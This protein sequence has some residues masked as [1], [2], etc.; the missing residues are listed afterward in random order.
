VAFDL[1][2]LSW[3][4]GFMANS[5]SCSAEQKALPHSVVLRADRPPVERER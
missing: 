2:R 5:M 4:K 3:P 1:P